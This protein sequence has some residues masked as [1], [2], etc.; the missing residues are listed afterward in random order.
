MM[1]THEVL[2]A[3]KIIEKY[4]GDSVFLFR[5]EILEKARVSLVSIWHN[6]IGRS[7]AEQAL[8][9]IEEGRAPCRLSYVTRLLKLFNRKKCLNVYKILGKTESSVAAFATKYRRELFGNDLFI[10]NEGNLPRAMSFRELVICAFGV[11]TILR[12]LDNRKKVK[13]RRNSE[14]Q[15]AICFRNKITPQRASILRKARKIIIEVKKCVELILRRRT[16]ILN[17]KLKIKEKRL[18]PKIK[19]DWSWRRIPNNWASL[20]L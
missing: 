10:D 5:Q 17:G 16:T 4:C 11:M 3:H 20:L 8:D 18:R 13:V 19:L 9:E 7:E 6:S 2:K 12:A 1:T 14:T 15:N